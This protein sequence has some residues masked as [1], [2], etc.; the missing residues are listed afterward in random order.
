VRGSNQLGQ[1]APQPYLLLTALMQFSHTDHLNGAYSLHRIGYEDGPPYFHGYTNAASSTRP[2][3]TQLSHEV[4]NDPNAI[5][6]SRMWYN[7]FTSLPPHPRYDGTHLSSIQELTA[8][9]CDTLRHTQKLMLTLIL[10]LRICQASTSER[11]L[12]RVRF[13]SFST[14]SSLGF[15]ATILLL[16]QLR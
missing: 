4:S 8:E 15:G 6:N 12:V 3:V 5:G 16:V 1:S 2:Y 11:I 10:R 14:I 13:N 7:G 9:N